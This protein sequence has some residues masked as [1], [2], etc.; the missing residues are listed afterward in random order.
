MR[1]EYSDVDVP[2]VDD[3][4]VHFI[5]RE[6]LCA[7]RHNLAV[8]GLAGCTVGPRYHKPS[9]ST[10]AAPNYKE[11][12]ANFQD[13]EGWKVA[14]PHDDMLHGNWWEVFQQ[15]ELN[16][17]EKQLN[18]DNQTI[19]VYFENYLA[20]RA[21]IRETRAQYYPTV[22]VGAGFTPLADLG[23]PR[24]GAERCYPVQHSGRYLLGAGFVWPRAQRR[25]KVPRRCPGK[26]CRS[27]K[28]APAR[29]SHAGRNYSSRFADRMNCNEFSNATV[30]ADEEVVKLAHAHATR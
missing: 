9:A 21:L 4:N 22:T 23:E 7:R 17:L 19:K 27:G 30:Q 10:P 15:P 16:D 24:P 20:A 8:L 11:S 25:A 6:K 1:R 3:K 26:C 14:S 2:E 12:P 18:I 13:A 28:R 29:T 5:V